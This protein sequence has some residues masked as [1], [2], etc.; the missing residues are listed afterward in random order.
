VVETCLIRAKW[1]C[2]EGIYV[3]NRQDGDVWGQK[4]YSSEPLIGHLSDHVQS[5]NSCLVRKQRYVRPRPP[6][7]MVEE[8]VNDGDIIGSC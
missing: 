8:G 5:V 7:G 2:E 1:R 4:S 6:A 3:G